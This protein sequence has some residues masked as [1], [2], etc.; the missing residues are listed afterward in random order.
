MSAANALDR[1]A[2]SINLDPT[3]TKPLREHASS[4]FLMPAEQL[5]ARVRDDP[6]AVEVADRVVR[7]TGWLAEHGVPVTIPADVPHPVAVDEFVITFWP[8]LPQH[9]A[10]PPISALGAILRS[11]HHTPNPPEQLPAYQPLDGFGTLVAASSALEAADQKWL[12]DR[13]AQ[14][15]GAYDAL[16]SQLGVGLIHGDAYQ[17]NLLWAGDT[18]VLGD[19][20]DVATGPRELDLANTYQSVRFGRSQADLD[21]L[22]TAYGHDIKDWPGLEVL[23]SIRDLHTLSA[24]IRSADRGSRTTAE[25]LLL[26]VSAL[27]NGDRHTRWTAH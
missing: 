1:A 18:V 17:G 11:L 6:A 12:L 16:D 19:W 26:R 22:A 3:D 25:E 8:Y 13:H 14:L 10:K 4:V 15:V 9:S 24:F 2:R 7:V 27:R 5:V 23:T 20:D 21:D